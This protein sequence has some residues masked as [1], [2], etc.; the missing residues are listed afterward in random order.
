MLYCFLQVTTF[1]PVK[2]IINQNLFT[3]NVLIHYH[4]D[5]RYYSVPYNYVGKRV[6]VKYSYQSIEIYKNNVRIAFHKRNYHGWG[7]TTIKEHMPPKH[8]FVSEWNSERFI[9]WASQNGNPVKEFVIKLLE[10][11]QHPEQAFKACMGV[12]HLAKKY[13]SKIMQIV[14]KYSY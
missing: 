9:S 14:C 12:M 3:N 11:K 5:K 4:E 13:D 10:N 6:T 8:R 2:K 7:Y 1:Y